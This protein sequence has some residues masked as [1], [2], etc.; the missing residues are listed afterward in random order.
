MKILLDT[1][2]L[3]W[4]LTNDPRLCEHARELLLDEKNEIY[5]SILS[6]WETELKRLAHPDAIAVTAK[7]LSK[8]CTK[9]G[10][11]KLPLQEQHIFAL[12]NLRREPDAPVHKDPF[13]RLLICQVCTEGMMFLTHDALILDYEER[14]ILAV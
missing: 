10:Y 5:Y 13:D 11:M 6:L 9:A 14:C 2:I 3:L 1:H 4:A 12:E 7:E 8:Y